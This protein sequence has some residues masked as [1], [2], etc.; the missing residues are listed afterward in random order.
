MLGLTRPTCSTAYHFIFSIL[1]RLDLTVFQKSTEHFLRD[2][3]A[4]TPDYSH[5]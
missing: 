1:Y 4:M 2:L 5:D 3:T